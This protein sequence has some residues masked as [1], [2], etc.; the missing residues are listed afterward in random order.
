MG[1]PKGTTLDGIVR[2][3]RNRADALEALNGDDES[4]ALGNLIASSGLFSQS[5]LNGKDE[6]LMAFVILRLAQLNQEPSDA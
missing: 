1:A 2:F 4:V 5:Y 3:L 6:P